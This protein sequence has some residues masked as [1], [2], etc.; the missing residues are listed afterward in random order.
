MWPKSNPLQLYT[1]E[2]INR[3]K[4]LDLI[5][6]VLKNLDGDSIHYTGGNDQDHPQEKQ[7]QKGRIVV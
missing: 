5:D 2:V 7:M 3:S 6:R 4:G 1:M